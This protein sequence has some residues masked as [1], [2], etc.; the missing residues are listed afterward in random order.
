VRI[1]ISVSKKTIVGKKNDAVKSGIGTKITGIARSLSIT[2]SRTLNCPLL[3]T[4]LNVMVMIG[5]T[6]PI[7]AITMMVGG[8]MGRLGEELPFMIGWGQTQCA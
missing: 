5:M 7:G 8:L 3:G 6:G 2:G 1:V 4:V